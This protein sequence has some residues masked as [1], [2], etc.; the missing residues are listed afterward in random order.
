MCVDS[1]A[2]VQAA[3]TGGSTLY[4]L[5]LGGDAKMGLMALYSAAAGC[6]WRYGREAGVLLRALAS[7]P[8][9]AIQ[10]PRDAACAARRALACLPARSVFAGVAP[11]RAALEAA[12]AAAEGLAAAAAAAP[13]GKEE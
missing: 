11:C 1:V 10:E 9:D 12:L 2:A 7:L 8:C 5:V 4:P 3:L 6:G 13:G